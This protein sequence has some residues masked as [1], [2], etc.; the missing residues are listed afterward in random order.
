MRSGSLGLL[1][2][3]AAA[4]A[5]A[6]HPM[7]GQ[8]PQ[9][10]LNGLLSGLGH[11]RHRPRP[12]RRGRWR[13]HP[14]GSC[15]PRD[16]AGPRLQRRRHRGR[17][18]PPCGHRPAGWRVAGGP[19]DTG[20][21]GLVIVRS[22]LPPLLAAS[23]FA[24]AGLVHGH[25]LGES[26]VGAEP[27][28]LAAYLLGLFVV[29]SA[30][31]VAAYIATVALVRQPSRGL[32]VS[33]MGAIVAVIGAA[34]ATAA[35][36]PSR[37]RPPRMTAS[38]LYVCTTCRS[39]TD[40]AT[41][42]PTRAGARCCRGA[43]LADDYPVSRIVGRRVSFELLARLHDCRRRARQVDLRDRQP[44]CRAARA[45]RARLRAPAQRPRNGRD[46]VARPT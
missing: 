25:A 2:S 40:G 1:V 20:H 12:S 45:G 28:P 43:G 24:L 3:L 26:I 37:S 38:T 30:I 34:A 6:H 41:V 33:A 23:L 46:G 7:G 32:G 31:A 35:T 17:R 29:Q 5:F 14:C 44:R 15:R 11:P 10:F 9:S 21:R 27:T 36:R 39:S 18:R 42:D 4:P 19:D 8:T 13:R 22:K 16:R